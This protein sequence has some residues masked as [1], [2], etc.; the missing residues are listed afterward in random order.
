MYPDLDMDEEPFCQRD[1]TLIYPQRTELLFDLQTETD[2][3]DEKQD[4]RYQG[5]I[6]TFNTVGNSA[7][8]IMLKALK[9]KLREINRSHD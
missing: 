8:N 4:P 3:D 1:K 2:N 6:N 9:P 5:S 7:N